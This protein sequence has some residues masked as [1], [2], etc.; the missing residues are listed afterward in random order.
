MSHASR[1]Y[2]GDTFTVLAAVQ[3]TADATS[4]TFDATSHSV[5]RAFRGLLLWVEVTA[6]PGT[7]P[8]VVFNIQTD[9]GTGTFTTV[10]ASAA[11]TAV[12]TTVLVVDPDVPDEANLTAQAVIEGPWRLFADHANADAIDYSVSAVYVP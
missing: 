3:R 1:R 9:D 12:G 6:T 2:P 5:P 11:V 7:A 4:A 10:L 8:S